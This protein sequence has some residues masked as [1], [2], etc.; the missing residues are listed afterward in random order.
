MEY[1]NTRRPLDKGPTVTIAG[2]PQP[3]ERFN[4][5]RRR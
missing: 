1:H 4:N 2:V 3:M 5:R